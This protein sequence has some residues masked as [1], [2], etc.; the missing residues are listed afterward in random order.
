MS[1]KGLD[2]F[3][4]D[5]RVENPGIDPQIILEA[6]HG[7]LFV[8]LGNWNTTQAREVARLILDTCDKAEAEFAAN[9]R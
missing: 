6:H 2:G 4:T 3:T 8:M 1:V 5:C 9:Q 7:T